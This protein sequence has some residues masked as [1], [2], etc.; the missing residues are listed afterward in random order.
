M[1]RH[2]CGNDSGRLRVPTVPGAGRG[3]THL[4][5]A[6]VERHFGYGIARAFAGHT[7]STGP[8]TTTHIKADI[9]AVAATLM[10]MT[11]QTHPLASGHQADQPWP[12]V[13]RPGLAMSRRDGCRARCR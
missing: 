3:S 9:E 7:D 1:N 2:H 13:R 11:G 6:W 10:A 5:C 8:A 12:A 4:S